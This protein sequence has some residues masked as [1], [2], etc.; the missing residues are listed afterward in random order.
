MVLM[1]LANRG[2]SLWALDEQFIVLSEGKS[3]YEMPV[4]TVDIHNANYRTVT[5]VTGTVSS[6]ATSYVTELTNSSSVA[7]LYIDSPTTSIVVSISADGVTYSNVT[8][9]AHNGGQAWYSI[10]TVSSTSFVKLTNATALTVTELKVISSVRDVP[11]YRLNR[12]DYLSLP[13]KHLP[14]VPL[15][16]WF[17]RQVIP[18]M[19]TWPVCDSNGSNNCIQIYRQRQLSDVGLLSEALD[20]PPRWL[21]AITWQLAANLAFEMPQVAPERI[22]LCSGKAQSALVEAEM[23]ERDNSPINFAPEI[24]V[25]TS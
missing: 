13:N 3:R 9:L 23:E 7:M 2:L 25:Y 12:D 14:G 10:D 20:I 19:L 1:N 11:I 24:G 8:T 15:Q 18:I 21:E 4:G 5:E 22:S 6:D 16:Y 17:D